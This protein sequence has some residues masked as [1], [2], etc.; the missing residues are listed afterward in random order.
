MTMVPTVLCSLYVDQQGE[1]GGPVALLWPSLFTDGAMWRSQVDA[2]TAVGWRT[3]TVDPPGHGRSA[4]PRRRFTM[5]ECADA[6]LTVLDAA[7]AHSPVLLLGTSWGGFVAPRVALRAPGR[8]LGMVLFNTSAER[9]GLLGRARARLLTRLLAI[10][11]LDRAV[12]GTIASSLLAPDT[13]R[14]R[15][16]VETDLLTRLRSWDRQ[17][18]ITAVRSVLVDR[19]PVLGALGQVACPALIVSGAEDRTLPSVHGHR[20]AAELPAGRHVE[21]D[22]AAHLVPLER[23]DAANR[24]I[25]DFATGLRGA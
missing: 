8:V 11:G 22:G 12:D 24:L 13:R 3:L 9:F 14:H 19:Q 6:A 4:S 20:M 2:L 18:L 21:V 25:L 16:E 17:G 23:A 15:P 10:G 7:G 1:A 5:D